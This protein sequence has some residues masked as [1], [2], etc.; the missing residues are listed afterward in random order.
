LKY[1]I[2]TSAILQAWLRHY[3]PDIFPPVWDR[4]DALIASAELVATE[5][6][7]REL[8]KQHDEI[9]MWASTR[10]PMFIPIDEQIQLSVTAILA[11]HPRLIDNRRN[12][13]GADPFVIALAQLN[14]ATVVTGEAPTG[15]IDKP[16]IPD[17]C[18][19]IGVQWIGFLQMIR[20]EGWTFPG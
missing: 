16:N 9:F 13:S 11:S 12:R 1:S 3:P 18:D 7:R 4:I 19:A 15:N 6:V 17:V 10:E 2:D 5:E 20:R 8:E 14:G